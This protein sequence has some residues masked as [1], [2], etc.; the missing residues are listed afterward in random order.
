M[1]VEPLIASTSLKR[2]VS[3]AITSS[4]QR[5]QQRLCL[6]EIGHVEA[7][8]EP[9]VDWREKVAGFLASTLLSPQPGEARGGAQFPELSALLL[10][11]LRALRYSSSAASVCPCRNSS[12]PLYLFS[13]ASSQCSPVLPAICEA[14]SV[15]VRAS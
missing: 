5:V 11:D 2:C 15:R 9:A 10:G 6:F 1:P 12:W 7:L 4:Q 3:S 14:S 13:S 8:G